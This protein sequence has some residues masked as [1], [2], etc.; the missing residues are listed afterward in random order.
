MQ[1]IVVAEHKV[2]LEYVEDEEDVQR[3]LDKLQV[4]AD[5]GDAEGH[6]EL[7]KDVEFDL[8][9]LECRLGRRIHLGVGDGF[10][11]FPLLVQISAKSK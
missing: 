1:L 8:K 4:V 2:S 3:E 7:R 9:R 10:T 5:E 6:H 11:E